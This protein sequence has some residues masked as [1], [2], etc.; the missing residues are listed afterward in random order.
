MPRMNIL[1][2]VEREAFE[3]PPVFNSFQ[4]KQYFDFPG[5]L[6]RL[7]GNLRTPTHRLGFLLSAGYFKAVK[8]FFQPNTFHRR[9]F[10]YVAR[11][12]EIGDPTFDFADYN[13]RTRQVHEVTIRAFYGFRVFD[14]EARRL[15]LGEIG[16]MVRSRFKPKLIFW[17]CIDALVRAKTEVPS[18]TRLT[19]LILD[20]VKRRKQELATLIERTLTPDARELLCRLLIQ[21][22]VEGGTAPGKTSA[23][24]LTLMKRLSQSTRPSKVK[25]RVADL[26]LVGDLHRQ[27][28]PALQALRL[29]PEGIR[30]YAHSVM[31]SK[32]FQLTRRDDPD[33]YL[34][35]IA[36]VAHQYY[37][38]QDN[39][40]DVL[41]TSLQ[42]FQNGAIR[43]HKEQCYARREQQHESLKV[44]VSYLDH[45]LVG[46]LATIN[47]ITEDGVLSDAEKVV[48]IRALLATKET[49]RLLQKDQVT[50]LK[51]ALVSELS[52]DNYYKILESKSV[53][54]QNRVSPILKA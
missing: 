21:E 10:A 9:D 3:L 25:E 27:L 43:E 28:S 35:L 13:P 54:S 2:A 18:Y 40:V 6:R 24:K 15:L 7:A 8:R 11:Q 33:R 37:R 4:R 41:L 39:L 1:N 5:E 32:I 19:K 12:L 31:R 49:R 23:Y 26:D 34:H 42:S 38:L 50:A 46:T 14:T 44:L 30:Y 17:R 53:W 51:E 22:S 52:E 45:T 29:N 48:R 20:A 16:S 36:F 47:T